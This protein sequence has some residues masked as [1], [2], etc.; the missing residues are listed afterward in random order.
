MIVMSALED[1]EFIEICHFGSK[2]QVICQHL[3]KNHE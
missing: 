1:G 2:S 3:L